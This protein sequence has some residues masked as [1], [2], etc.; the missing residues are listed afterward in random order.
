MKKVLTTLLLSAAIVGNT[1]A[2]WNDLNVNYQNQVRRYKVY[3]P[4]N[5]STNPSLVVALHGMGQNA[6][7]ISQTALTAISDTAN[8]ILIAPEGLPFTHTLTGT[9]NGMWNVG[10]VISNALVGTVALND[11]ID[12]IGFISL[13]TDSVIQ[14]YGVDTNSI[15]AMGFSLGAFMTQRLACELPNTFKAIASLSGS[16]ASTLPTCVPAQSIPTAIFYGTNDAVVAADGTYTLQP[17]GLPLNVG[18]SFDSLKQFWISKNNTATT[19][20]VDT[21]GSASNPYYIIRSQYNDAANEYPVA[22]YSIIN[23][24]HNWYDYSNT[25]NTFDLSH[26]SWYFFKGNR[27]I[28]VG[29]KETTAYQEMKVYPNPATTTLYLDQ[30]KVGMSFT[31]AAIFNYLGQEVENVQIV[32][33]SLKIE[34]LTPGMYLLK[35]TDNKGNIFMSKF[36]KQ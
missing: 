33:N 10:M 18:I 25:N 26:L 13:I 5:L 9:I 35:M 21:I 22:Y 16:R 19:P 14:Q 29:I 24:Q 6:D 28:P 1:N 11:N 31:N 27:N 8:M 34:H 23:G 20:E 4:N 36:I 7:A 32:N 2:G 12:D 30:N 3:V 17:L 15:Y